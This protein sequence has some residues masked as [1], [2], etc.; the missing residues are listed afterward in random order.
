MLGGGQISGAIIVAGLQ[1][2]NEVK[3]GFQELVETQQAS[4]GIVADGIISGAERISH[5]LQQI[6]SELERQTRNQEYQNLMASIKD[7]EKWLFENGMLKEFYHSAELPAATISLVRPVYLNFLSEVCGWC[8]VEMNKGLLKRYALMYNCHPLL[9]LATIL[10][11]RGIAISPD[12]SWSYV[13]EFL[14]YIT[15]T[16]FCWRNKDILIAPDYLYE[17]RTCKDL[18]FGNEK[19]SFSG[20]NQNRY[21]ISNSTDYG[22]LISAKLGGELSVRYLKEVASCCE[23]SAEI[24][25]EDRLEWLEFFAK[26]NANIALENLRMLANKLSNFVRKKRIEMF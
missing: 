23:Q 11:E 22:Q 19:I 4:S 1:I 2:A 24:S 16:G 5:G 3:I 20:I 6:A 10:E 21:P 12:A 13:D 8:N 14:V 25:E 15:G 9:Y 18:Q 26:L 7:D 17:V